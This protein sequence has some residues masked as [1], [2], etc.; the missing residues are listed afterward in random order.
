MPKMCND[1]HPK[2]DTT[3]VNIALLV[4]EPLLAPCPRWHIY[5][6]YTCMLDKLRG[7][8]VATGHECR[9][10]ISDGTQVTTTTLVI[11]NRCSLECDKVTRRIG[12]MQSVE[13]SCGDSWA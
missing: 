2:W 3:R 10:M 9:W 8:T 12:H 11:V 1:I 4:A 5:C 13:A 7:M 6:A